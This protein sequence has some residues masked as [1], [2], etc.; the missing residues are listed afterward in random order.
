ME[1]TENQPK[2]GEAVI[3]AKYIRMLE[4]QLHRKVGEGGAGD[5]D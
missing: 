5:R 3:T 4:D 1:E 2:E